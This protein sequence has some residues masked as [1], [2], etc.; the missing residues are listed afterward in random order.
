MRYYIVEKND[1]SICLGMT[2]PKEVMSELGITN[3]E[4]SKFVRNEEV[5]KGGILIPDDNDEKRYATSEDEEEWRLFHTSKLYDYYVSN[6]LR[7][8]SKLKSTGTEYEILMHTQYGKFGCTYL[9]VRI[10]KRRFSVLREAYK[11]F[12][13]KNVSDHYIACCNGSLKLENIKLVKRGS[14]GCKKV[15]CDGVVYQS[16]KECADS[17]GYTP[18]HVRAMASGIR[19]NTV[20]VKYC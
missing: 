8:I 9:F 2:T 1:P 17:I 13:N 15:I 6:K 5:Y 11:A 3:T 10:G 16:I 12:I 4:F 14:H 19:K 18:S 7:V 20:G